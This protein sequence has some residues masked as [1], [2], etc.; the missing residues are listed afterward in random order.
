LEDSGFRRICKAT[1]S[2]YFSD[3]RYLGTT[4]WYQVNFRVPQ[5]VVSG[6][7]ILE[8]VAAWI[9]GPSVNIPFDEPLIVHANETIKA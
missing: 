2:N 9:P 1:L 6:L 5:G 8:I 3:R 4:D 7:A